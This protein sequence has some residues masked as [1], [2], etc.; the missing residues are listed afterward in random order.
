VGIRGKGNW[1][2]CSNTPV[3]C[4]SVSDEVFFSDKESCVFSWHP[5]NWYAPDCKFPS[6]V[7]S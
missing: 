7:K 3:V 6:K 5:W 1:P 2:K 4:C